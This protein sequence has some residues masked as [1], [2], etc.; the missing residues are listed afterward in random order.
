MSDRVPDMF[1]FV[2]LE[3]HLRLASAGGVFQAFPWLGVDA[4]GD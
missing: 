3:W 1:V 2:G 4:C